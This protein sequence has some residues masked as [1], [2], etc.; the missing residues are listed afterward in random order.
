MVRKTGGSFYDGASTY[1]YVRSWFND[2]GVFGS[3]TL[4]SN[5]NISS[6]AFVEVGPN[7]EYLTWEN[8]GVSLSA[9]ATMSGLQ[10]SPGTGYLGLGVDFSLSATGNRAAVTRATLGYDELRSMSVTYNYLATAGRHRVALLGAISGG[11][12]AVYYGSATAQCGVNVSTSG[13]GL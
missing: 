7:V 12:T 10:P 5:Q 6:S 2:P 9:D 1:R 4:G 3:N 11:G 13:S 8:E